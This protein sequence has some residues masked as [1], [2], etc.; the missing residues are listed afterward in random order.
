MKN[1]N[2]DKKLGILDWGIGG[3]GF[4]RLLKKSRPEVPVLY[5]SD[6]GAT[7][8]GKMEKS[9]LIHR[10]EKILSYMIAERCD[11]ICIACHSASIAMPFIQ[12][13]GVPV[14]NV[15]QHTIQLLQNLPPSL[16][17]GGRGTILSG[18]YNL[19]GRNDLLRIAQPLSAFVESG[20]LDSKELIRQIKK[21]VSFPE[22]EKIK[23]IQNIVLACTHYVALSSQIS[24]IVGLEYA[25]IDPVEFMLTWVEKNWNLQYSVR[26][27]VLPDIFLTTG[28]RDS[29]IESSKVAFDLIVDPD[30]VIHV[31][32]AVFASQ[33]SSRNQ[34]ENSS[35]DNI[36]NT[37]R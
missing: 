22:G 20:D 37:L 8:Y 15:M 28:S 16:I 3:L 24:A 29:F 4:Y 25:I 5:F 11:R 17:L 21:I 14:T 35:F 6:A 27:N 19:E 26:Q 13:I 12:N 34:Q 2:T 7:P 10:I 31:D 30:S 36:A 1:L 33:D 9:S 23:N 32:E 18:M